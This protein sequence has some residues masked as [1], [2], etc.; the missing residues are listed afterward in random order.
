MIVEIE[1]IANPPGTPANQYEHIEAAIKVIEDSGLHYEVDA[2]GTTVEG[3]PDELWPLLRAVHD[4]TLK[5]G[6]NSVVTVIKAAQQREDRPQ[7]TM[8][9]LT[10]KFR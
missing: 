2:L 5:A 6:A 3:E 9:S 8:A 10:G 4:A 1:C 7:A